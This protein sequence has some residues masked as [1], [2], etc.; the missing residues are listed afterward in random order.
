MWSET[1]FQLDPT[2]DKEY[3]HYFSD[4]NNVKAIDMA[5]PKWAIFTMGVYGENSHLLSDPTEILFLAI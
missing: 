4:V 3:P 1:K 2:K 5:L